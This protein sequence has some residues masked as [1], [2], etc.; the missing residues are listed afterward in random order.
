MSARADPFNSAAGVHH[1]EVNAIDPRP[2][3]EWRYA[4]QG[5]AFDSTS[6]DGS[7][8]LYSCGSQQSFPLCCSLMNCLSKTAAT[9]GNQ[10]TC[11]MQHRCCTTCKHSLTDIVPASGH[12]VSL[13]E[14]PDP[15][16]HDSVQNG[17]SAEQQLPARHN[18]HTGMAS[19]GHYDT[20]M[21][22]WKHDSVQSRWSAERQPSARHSWH[23]MLLVHPAAGHALLCNV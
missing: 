20:Y 9:H 10:P 15:W 8:L 2:P 1:D 19:I 14:E 4:P 3:V 22:L 11:A 7:L 13:L 16:E 6:Q 17:W 12:D 21:R 23:I 5:A 18:W